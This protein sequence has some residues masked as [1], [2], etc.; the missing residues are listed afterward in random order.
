MTSSNSIL[1]KQRTST[2]RPRFYHLSSFFLLI[3]KLTILRKLKN[4]PNH[5]ESHGL[6]IFLSFHWLM[7]ALEEVGRLAC[8]FSSVIIPN[9]YTMLVLLWQYHLTMVF[10]WKHHELSIC[11][12]SW[13]P[14]CVTG[15]SF[16]APLPCPP[17]FCDFI[18]LS[19]PELGLWAA[20]FTPLLQTL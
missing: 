15:R 7:Y 13:F 8:L 2:L 1:C 20:H 4:S 19:A 9:S 18:T 10:V 5:N 14:S 12:F 16:S 11:T 17:L 3:N 6:K